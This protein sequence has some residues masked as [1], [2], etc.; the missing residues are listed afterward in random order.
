MKRE[1]WSQNYLF[2]LT[3][4][5]LALVDAGIL[6]PTRPIIIGLIFIDRSG[7]EEDPYVVTRVFNPG[8][9]DEIDSWITDVQYAVLHGEDA[10]RDIPAPVCEQICEFFTVCRGTLPMED[11][12]FLTD[13]TTRGAIEMYVE[14]RA[15]KSE[16]EAAMEEAKQMLKGVDGTTGEWVVRHTD[17]P[18]GVVPG[19]SRRAYSKMEIVRQR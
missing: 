13:P 19:Y 16:A 3:T 12:E 6:D 9:E 11:A 17:V 14:A 15:A 2:Q 4:Y 5:A 18:E 1:P 7:G 8:I 10:S